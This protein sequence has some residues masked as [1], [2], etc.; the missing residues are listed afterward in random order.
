M[1]RQRPRAAT[2]TTWSSATRQ[3]LAR[4]RHRQ[5]HAVRRLGQRPAQRRRRPR[6]PTTTSTT[7]PDTAPSYEDRAVRRRRPRRADRQ[8][9]RRPPDRLGRRVQLATSCRSRRS[10][11]A[12]VSRQVPPRLFEFLYDAVQGAGRRP[13]ASAET[14][15]DPRPQRRAV[16]RARPGHAEGQRAVAGPDRRPARPAARQ[17]P[18]WQ[19]R[20]AA[21][22]GLQRRPRCSGFFVDSGNLDGQRRRA[23]GGGRQPRQGRCVGLLRRRLPADLLRDH[24]VDRSRRSRPAA[25]RPTPT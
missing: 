25:G 22:R 14:G 11:C 21:L 13:D 20:R 5:R 4:R 2:A 7:S 9:R 18:R 6:R 1:R 8:H 10:A 3:R 17:H 12:T 16:R 24:R 15:A 19:A 23:A